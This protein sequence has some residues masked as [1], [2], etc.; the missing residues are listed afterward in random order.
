MSL[1]P[2]L[3]KDDIEKELEVVYNQF[4]SLSKRSDD[5]YEKKRLEKNYDILKNKLIELQ[6]QLMDLNMLISK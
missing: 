4:R 2:S 6:G 5:L 3:L 1:E